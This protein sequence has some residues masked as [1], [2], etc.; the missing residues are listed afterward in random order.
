MDTRGK[1]TLLAGRC[2]VRGSVVD[3]RRRSRFGSWQLGESS[4]SS[5]V[6]L[7]LDSGALGLQLG[8]S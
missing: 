8:T 6:G 4:Y 2:R 7:T 5:F 1:V 3:R